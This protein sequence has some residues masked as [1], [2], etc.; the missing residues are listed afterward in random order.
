[1]ERLIIIEILNTSFKYRSLSSG[2][3][4]SNQLNAG[5]AEDVHDGLKRI[6][7]TKKSRKQKRRKR[8]GKI[9]TNIKSIKE[10]REA[11]VPAIT[12]AAAKKA[13]KKV[14]VNYH[15]LSFHLRRKTQRKRM[16]REWN[17]MNGWEKKTMYPKPT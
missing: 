14:Q 6:E 15:M 12:V 1:M 7:A 4:A 13:M 3:F 10:Q 8:N 16:A 2:W 9:S 5:C 17:E 11:A